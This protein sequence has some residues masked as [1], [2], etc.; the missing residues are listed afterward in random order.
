[1]KKLLNILQKYEPASVKVARWVVAGFSSIT[2]E[3][4]I[5]SFTHCRHFYTH[6][7]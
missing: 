5:A 3:C 4:V 1:M 6:S 7:L 2:E